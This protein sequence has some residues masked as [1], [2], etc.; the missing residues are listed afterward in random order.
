LSPS[1]GQGALEEE[2]NM[3]RLLVLV[4]LATVL[5]GCGNK[6]NFRTHH[7]MK[8]ISMSCKVCGNTDCPMVEAKQR[9]TREWK[10]MGE[11]K[12]TRGG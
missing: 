10:R 2:R 1:G 5:I 12:K 7:P 8:T 3:I 9:E 4:F 11:R 6:R